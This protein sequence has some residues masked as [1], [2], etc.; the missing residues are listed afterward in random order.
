MEQKEILGRDNMTERV[1]FKCNVC[2]A[3]C[4]VS[5]MIEME[6]QCPVPC[7]ND[8]FDPFWIKVGE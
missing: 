2:S 7:L 1:K 3:K 6:G 4:R 5:M 8:A